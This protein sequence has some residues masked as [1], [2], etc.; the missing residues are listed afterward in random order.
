MTAPFQNGAVFF[1]KP[2]C[3]DGK[4]KKISE[5]DYFIR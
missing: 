5:I 2:A 1:V 4:L 3:L